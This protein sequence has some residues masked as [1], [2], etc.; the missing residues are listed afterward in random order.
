M[1]IKM[2]LINV[3]TYNW[4]EIGKQLVKLTGTKS[5][6]I[7]GSVDELKQIQKGVYW[8][9]KTRLSFKIST[10]LTNKSLVISRVKKR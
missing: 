7:T 9:A 6:K 8:Y 2:E 4:M 10:E 3:K 5:L 1:S